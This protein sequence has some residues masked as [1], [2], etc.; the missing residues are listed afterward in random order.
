MGTTGG[1][2]ATSGT[3]GSTPLRGGGG[4]AFG[5]GSRRTQAVAAVGVVIVAVVAVVLAGGGGHA[6][7]AGLPK[8]GK[9]PSWLP[10]PAPPAN[11]I[12]TATE[13]KPVLAAIEGNTV[14]AQLAGGSA[15]VT[16]VGPAVPSWVASDV[17]GGH[18]QSGETAPSTFTVT[19]AQ[20]KGDVPLT[21][22]DF[23]I[24]TVNGQTVHPAMSV[25][26]GGSLPARLT[27][28]SHLTV[29]L[30]TGLAEGEGAVRWI[31]SGVRVLVAW[32]YQLELD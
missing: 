6:A 29:D 27:P 17:Q 7:S 8:Y 14:H 23:Q 25:A 20:V 26:G 28:G 21:P 18:W 2:V 19:F 24:V 30:R 11:Q 3:A 4:R 16:T 5:P 32:T 22:S 31:P 15:M 9:I 12:A 13:A 1:S 10:N